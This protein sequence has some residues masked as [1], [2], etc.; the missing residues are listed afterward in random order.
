MAFDALDDSFAYLSFPADK[1]G[2]NCFH[3]I[4]ETIGFHNLS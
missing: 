4:G 2:V 1:T 3:N